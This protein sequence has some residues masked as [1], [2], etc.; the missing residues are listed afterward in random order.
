MSER[1]AQEVIDPEW[2]NLF[3]AEVSGERTIEEDLRDISIFS[4]LTDKELGLLARTVHLRHY[5]SGEVVVHRGMPQSGFYLIRSG[6]VQIVRQHFDGTSEVVARLGRRELL[7]E[8]ALVDGT[9]RT[10]SIVAG[11]PSELIGFFKPDLMGIL[12]TKPRMGCKILLR[13]AE[14]MAHTLQQDY[15]ALRAMGF[16][17]PD[18]DFHAETALVTA[19]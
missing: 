2:E 12:S 6:S 19:S 15:T 13:L 4:L 9:P 10:S 16:P 8:F 18:Q 3:R 17:H 5:A 14:T 7:G 1:S 11:E